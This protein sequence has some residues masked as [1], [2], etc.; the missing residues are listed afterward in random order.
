VRR[1]ATRTSGVLA[2][3]LVAYIRQARGQSPGHLRG[4]RADLQAHRLWR[5]LVTAEAQTQQASTSGARLAEP[6]LIGDDDL[7]QSVERFAGLAAAPRHG[8]FSPR[9]R[10]RDRAIVWNTEAGAV[11]QVL[12]EIRGRQRPGR[13]EA[14]DD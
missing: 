3:V 14:V 11:G 5:W 12:L 7:R 4:L 8:R 2:V 9:E 13:V 10:A 1:L 6:A